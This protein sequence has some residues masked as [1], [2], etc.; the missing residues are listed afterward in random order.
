[1]KCTE[2]DESLS[3]TSTT[4]LFQRKLTY[5]KIDKT[6]SQGQGSGCLA[7]LDNILI[8]SRTKKVHLQMLDKAFKHLLKAGLKLKLIKCSF[9]KEKVTI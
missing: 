7:Y 8:Y 4:V 1:M 2:V 9:F 3:T 6:S 5:F